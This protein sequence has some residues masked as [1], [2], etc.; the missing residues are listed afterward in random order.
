MEEENAPPLLTPWRHKENALA[1]LKVDTGAVSKGRLV[2]DHSPCAVFTINGYYVPDTSNLKVFKG[3]QQ[4]YRQNGKTPSKGHYA[5]AW[6]D[7]G[8]KPRD[9]SYEVAI[10]VRGADTISRLA[11]N[12]ESPICKRKYSRTNRKHNSH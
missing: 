4:S 10:L 2:Q 12:P 9:A 8:I 1:R 6:L 5:V 11:E 7:Y 3:E